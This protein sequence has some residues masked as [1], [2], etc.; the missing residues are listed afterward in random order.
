MIDG[1]MFA[2]HVIVGLLSIFPIII[3][4]FLACIIFAVVNPKNSLWAF[5]TTIVASIILMQY[6]YTRQCQFGF[7]SPVVTC[8]EELH[9][10]PIMWYYVMLFVIISCI[11]SIKFYTGEKYYRCAVPAIIIYTLVYINI[12]MQTQLHGI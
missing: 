6:E 11:V 4:S 9:Y 8:S 2:I 7:N 1:I 12:L 3:V 10:M 5:I